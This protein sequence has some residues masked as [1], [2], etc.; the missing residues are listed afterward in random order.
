MSKTKWH[1]YTVSLAARQT[2]YELFEI[3]LKPHRTT[4]YRQKP[5][6]MID[7]LGAVVPEATLQ[8]SHVEGLSHALRQLHRTYDLYDYFPK[9]AIPMYL[10]TPGTVPLFY[11]PPDLEYLQDAA[12]LDDTPWEELD[13]TEKRLR[14]ME[15]SR[16]RGWNPESATRH[17]SSLWLCL[18]SDTRRYY[19]NLRVFHS[20][21][22]LPGC[23]HPHNLTASISAVLEAIGTKHLELPADYI[24]AIDEPN[25]RKARAATSHRGPTGQ[26]TFGNHAHTPYIAKEW[27]ALPHISKFT[28]ADVDYACRPDN[29]TSLHD[30]AE[31]ACAL[32]PA[33]QL[34]PAP[35]AQPSTTT[36]V[37]GDL[38]DTSPT[39]VKPH[40]D[41]VPP[42]SKPSTSTYHYKGRDVTKYV[43]EAHDRH[44]HPTS[45]ET[46]PQLQ[47]LADRAQLPLY[48][49][50]RLATREYVR[51]L[52]R[53]SANA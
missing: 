15:L 40:I 23:R 35:H 25:K 39:R 43:L 19:H 9:P 41:L 11:N 14:L 3:A 29:Y 45:P 30:L 32:N 12:T 36:P 37:S 52:D 34:P 48:M 44:Y 10:T 17:Y 4:V 18:P 33:L 6:R 38:E 22:L 42:T 46:F 21:P 49:L 28:Q 53:E 8:P 5:T 13:S 47:D 7:A 31:E 50:Q 16:I 27:R 26:H 2:L 20:I 24:Y 51:R 1:G